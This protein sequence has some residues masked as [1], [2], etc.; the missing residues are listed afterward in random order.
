M[1]TK[2]QM[3][4]KTT[5]KTTTVRYRNKNSL[6]FH[7]VWLQNVFFCLG[8]ASYL[9]LSYNFS[10]IIRSVNLISSPARMKQKCCH[11]IGLLWK[12]ITVSP[13]AFWSR[14]SCKLLYIVFVDVC[15]GHHSLRMWHPALV[16]FRC[17]SW[18]PSSS[19]RSAF[20]FSH[21]SRVF[22][23]SLNNRWLQNFHSHFR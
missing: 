6:Y 9:F 10:F 12:F 13:K 11:F 16:D 1:C 7:K 17:L 15:L 2:P 14:I 4:D 20:S 3:G 18:L 23:L 21:V 5:Q 22:S 8:H 19:R